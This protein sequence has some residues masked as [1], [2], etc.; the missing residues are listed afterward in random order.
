M[1]CVYL[2]TLSEFDAVMESSKLKVWPLLSASSCASPL[3]L[4]DLA[5]GKDAAILPLLKS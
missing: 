5:E 3:G 2:K 1:P 4:P